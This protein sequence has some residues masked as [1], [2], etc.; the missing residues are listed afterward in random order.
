MPLHE[1][2]WMLEEYSDLALKLSGSPFTVGVAEEENHH[3]MVLL[4]S[5][6]EENH[7]IPP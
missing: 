7:H 1:A 3:T 5:Y 4:P 6:Y 2:T